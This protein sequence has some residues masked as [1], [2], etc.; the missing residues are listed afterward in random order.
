MGLLFLFSKDR[1]AR[2]TAPD[3]IKKGTPRGFL[4][5]WA[6]E[7]VAIINTLACI[8]LIA[9]KKQMEKPL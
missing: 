1:K 2:N 4:Y 8:V 9:Y 3:A 6:A 7:R 5:Q